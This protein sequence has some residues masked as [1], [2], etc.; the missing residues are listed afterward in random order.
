VAFA[1]T[2]GAKCEW[3]DAASIRKCLEKAQSKTGQSLNLWQR[4]VDAGYTRET[5]EIEEKEIPPEKRR[6]ELLDVLYRKG[7]AGDPVSVKAYMELS[8]TEE[9]KVAFDCNVFIQTY[10]VKDPSLR[11]IVL[12]AD[13][14]PVCELAYALH[15]RCVLD[16]FSRE[17]TDKMLTAIKGFE[18]EATVKFRDTTKIPR[19]NPDASRADLDLTEETIDTAIER[20][21]AE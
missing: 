18:A 6:A 12:E 2:V 11:E 7:L 19:F 10:R 20:V 5:T 15:E 21:M 8:Q 13:E 16:G 4:L 14:K 9:K 17:V 3:W 1:R